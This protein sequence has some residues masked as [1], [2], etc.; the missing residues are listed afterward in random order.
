MREGN[1][2]CTEIYILSK[3]NMFFASK[4]QLRKVI[5]WNLLKDTMINDCV[6]KLNHCTGLFYLIHYNT[7]Q[8]IC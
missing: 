7:V 5:D 2:V 3:L 4:W 6:T 8:N 1:D